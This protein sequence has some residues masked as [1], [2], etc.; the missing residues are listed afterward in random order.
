MWHIPRRGKL[1]RPVTNKV[2][3]CGTTFNNQCESTWT[4]VNF[5]VLWTTL[6]LGGN[7]WW[8]KLNSPSSMRVVQAKKARRIVL[9]KM[10]VQ[11]SI[12]CPWGKCLDD[13]KHLEYFM[14]IYLQE[15]VKLNHMLSFQGM[16][17]I[18]V[19]RHNFQRQL[20]KNIL[21]PKAIVE[22]NIETSDLL[23]YRGS[24]K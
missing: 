4:A 21:T 9:S 13:P 20:Q 5:A 15:P 17:K 16:S 19:H 23:K 24:Y 6:G 1:T 3:T 10:V 14:E 12:G 18:W 8:T 7:W 2:M 11:E 22:I